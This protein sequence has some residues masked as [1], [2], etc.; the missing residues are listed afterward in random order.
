MG[1]NPSCDFNR[2]QTGDSTGKF[3]F[4]RFRTQN[5]C[6]RRPR[7]TC[8]EDITKKIMQQ[9][10]VSRFNGKMFGNSRITHEKC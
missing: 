2:Q 8:Q 1:N 6:F 5:S 9:G 4:N 7:T 10:E 3:V